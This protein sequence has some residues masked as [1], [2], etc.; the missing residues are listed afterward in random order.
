MI[1][2]QQLANTEPNPEPNPEPNLE[3]NFEPNTENEGFQPEP[4]PPV[5]LPPPKSI[6]REY[7]EQGVITVIMALFLMTFIAQAVQVPTG[8]MQN[9]I[10]IGDHLFVNKF[11]FGQ[12]TPLIGPLLPGREIR[13]GDIIVFKYPND[14]KVNYVKRVVGLPGDKVMVRGTR[15]FIN[16]QELPEQRVIVD[17]HIS[18]EYSANPELRVEPALPGATYRVYYN[19]SHDDSS[20]PEDDISGDLDTVHGPVIVPDN[21]YFAMGDNRDNSQDSRVWGFVPRANIV[22]RALYVYWSFNRQDPD[23]PTSTSSNRLIA[24]LVDFF[25]KTNWRRTGKAIK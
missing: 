17:V 7:F 4:A 18:Q 11:V 12:Q 15:I 9:N 21:S 14:P 25:V 13:R 20:A 8:S 24:L 10:N 16:D 23:T 1:E 3:L 6:I 5:Y 2:Q 19:K 22:G